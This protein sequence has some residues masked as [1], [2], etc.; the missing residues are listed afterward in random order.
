VKQLKIAM[1]I[2]CYDDSNN[3]AVISTKRFVELLKKDGHL[4]SV[5]TTGAP[6]PGKILLPKFYPFGVKR[7]MK[8]MHTPLAIPS[9]KILR[10][11]IKEMDIV[12]IQFPFFLAI[13]SIKV[14]RR[15]HIPVVT[16][17]HIQAEHLASNAGIHS[18]IFIFY[19]YKFWIKQIYNKSDLVICPSKFAESELQKYGLKSP[20]AILSNGFLPI[21]KPMKVD[22]EDG[23][24]NKFIILSV[25]RFAPEKRHELIIHA[26]K[27]SGYQE[28][29]QL[30][31]IGDGPMKE[32]LVETGNVLAN[33]PIFLSL[34]PEEL[35]YYYNVSD[36]YVHAATV[37]VECMTVLEA[38]GCALPVLIADCP[39][40]A[41]KQF[42]LNQMSL[43]AKDNVEDLTRKIEYWIDRPD[44]LAKLKTMYYESSFKYHIQQS[45]E[46][47]L[48]IYYG[49]IELKSRSK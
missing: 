46:K 19:C 15:L 5:I 49:L 22:R 27:N 29:I 39:K 17:F 20:A 16:T 43:F 9:R 3:G 12:H 13:N 48:Q 14:A 33:P 44:E 45:Y 30:I 31:L 34:S 6:A 10:K 4:V 38:M 28:K 32:K 2:D 25:G 26:I 47:L 8:R 1:V 40:S 37:E 11:T 18:R 41:T 21:F 36:L 7:I 35:V 24:K 42:A 23:L